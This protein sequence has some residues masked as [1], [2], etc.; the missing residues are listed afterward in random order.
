MTGKPR[1]GTVLLDRA[2]IQFALSERGLSWT[3]TKPHC[4]VSESTW[5][6]ISRG[7]RVF[8]KTA[9]EV[10]RYLNFKVADLLVPKDD[11]GDTEFQWPEHPEWKMVAAEPGWPTTSNGLSYF[12]CKVEH[13]H[14]GLPAVPQ[15]GRARFYDLS[16]VPDEDR[17]EMTRRLTRHPL[18]CREFSECPYLVVNLCAAP[19]AGGQFWW[20]I[21]K[22]FEGQV[23]SDLIDESSID[24]SQLNP[25]M[26]QV[27]LGLSALHERGYLIR[28]LSPEN[29]LVGETGEVRL[30]ELDL[31]KLLFTDKTVSNG[32][33]TDSYRAPEVADDSASVRS[34][35]YS[36]AMVYLHAAAGDCSLNRTAVDSVEYLSQHAE[37]RSLLRKCLSPRASQR[38]ESAHQLI[39]VLQA[40]N[41]G[42]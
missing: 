7:A 22:W 17:E 36:W 12:R 1:N 2:K 16:R 18:V 32:W 20:V 42:I 8:P 38:P 41:P 37:I 14:V 29:V 11:L 19:V 35:L 23:L 27:A 13:R 26:M 6:R 28:E 15:Y 21:D 34:D 40:G 5:R 3:S 39:S 25:I 33:S 4:D 30:T 10:A 9:E 24:L 31:A